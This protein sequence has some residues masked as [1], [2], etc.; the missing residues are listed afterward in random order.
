[1]SLNIAEVQIFSDICLNRDIVIEQLY[2]CDDLLNTQ[3]NF[4]YCCCIFV[5]GRS[6]LGTYQIQS[7]LLS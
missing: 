3:I 6:Y 5:S 7:Y 4:I 2:D 1:M